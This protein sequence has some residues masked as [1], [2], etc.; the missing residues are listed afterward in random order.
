MVEP[1]SQSDTGLPFSSL[2]MSVLTATG[3]NISSSELLPSTCLPPL[4]PLRKN[5]DKKFARHPRLNRASQRPGHVLGMTIFRESHPVQRAYS[6]QQSVS[7]F[8][9][10][11]QSR[12]DSS[13]E[14]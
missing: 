14:V 6:R 2:L 3:I 5:K 10:L 13:R 9:Q 7:S 1:A 12:C 11:T 4:G 8:A